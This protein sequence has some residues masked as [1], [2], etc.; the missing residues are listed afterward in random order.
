[1]RPGRFL[2]ASTALGGATSSHARREAQRQHDDGHRGEVERAEAP[3]L[4]TAH[5]SR[6][7]VAAG[8][9]AWQRA[10]CQQAR[11]EL[12]PF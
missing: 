1:M 10:E 6:R 7:H 2:C 11:G 4:G 3:G 5:A 12:P 9:T 8:P